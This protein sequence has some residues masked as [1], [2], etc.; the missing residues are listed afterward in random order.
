MNWLLTFASMFAKPVGA[1]IN[2]GL[3]AGAAAAIT[4]AVTKGVPSETAVTV[5]GSIVLAISTIISGVAATQGVTIPIINADPANGVR[6]VDAGSAVAA[7]LPKVD[8]PKS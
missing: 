3:A 5:A 7:G 8:S 6:V 4:W 2:K 1:L